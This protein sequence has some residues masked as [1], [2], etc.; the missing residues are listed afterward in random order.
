MKQENIIKTW[1][2]SEKSLI[3]GERVRKLIIEIHGNKVEIDDNLVYVI[4]NLNKKGYDTQFCC[5][6]HI[7]ICETYILFWKSRLKNNIP[8]G[9]KKDIRLGKLHIF[10]TY[11]SE[12]EKV[13]M[14]KI[15]KDWV[16]ELEDLGKK[17][18]YHH[19]PRNVKKQ[20]EKPEKN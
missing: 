1:K 19:I 11:H 12:E 7:P 5:E 8:K 16:D 14:M 6:G 13:E 9:F 3:C 17:S 15:L 18:M 2:N 4:V 10:R 20:S